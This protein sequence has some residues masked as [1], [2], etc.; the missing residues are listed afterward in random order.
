M[1]SWEVM[2]FPVGELATVNASH[3]CFKRR[4]LPAGSSVVGVIR[5]V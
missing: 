4:D 2:D 3:G 1:V 5:L